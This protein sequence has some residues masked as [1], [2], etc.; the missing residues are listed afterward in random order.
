MALLG[1][2]K[3]TSYFYQNPKIL[4]KTLK[5]FKKYKNRKKIV[6]ILGFQRTCWSSGMDPG[7]T[8][9]WHQQAP[10]LV[11]E[12][13]KLGP[14]GPLWAHVGPYGSSWTRLG[15][16]VNFPS[17]FRQTFGPISHASGP[18]MVF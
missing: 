7:R 12:K 4:L 9:T 8:D 13:R 10:G 1:E 2:A 17:D 5:I 14:C 18:K 6:K 11:L 3:K 16:S 15:S